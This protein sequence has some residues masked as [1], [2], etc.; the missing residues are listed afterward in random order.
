MTARPIAEV[1]AGQRI[2]LTGATGFV[3]EALLE[4]LAARPARDA[5][6]AAGAPA[7]SLTGRASGSSSCSRGRPSAGC[8]SGAATTSA[9]L[10]DGSRSPCSRATSTTSRRSRRPRHRHP[11]RRRGVVRPGDR[12]RLRDQRPR[13]AEPARRDR[14]ERQPS[15]TTCTSPPRTSPVGSRATSAKAGSTTTSTGAARR[16]S[17]PQLRE[18]AEIDSRTAAQLADLPRRGRAE[19]GASGALSVSAEAERRRR[20]WVAKRWSTP[21]ASAAAAWVD[22]LLHVH[23]GDGGARRRGDRR[24]TCR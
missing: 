2:L 19:H 9:P 3:G 18:R 17:P 10:L 21:A 4:T 6:R 16:R 12:R 5:G 23:Q 11:L 20:E 24:R 15:R 8:A 22:R 7:G 1:L 14:G 13:H